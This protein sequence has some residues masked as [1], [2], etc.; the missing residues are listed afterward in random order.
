MISR[1]EADQHV[2]EVVRRKV[3]SLAETNLSPDSGL[4]SSADHFLMQR[5]ETGLADDSTEVIDRSCGLDHV[6]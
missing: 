5:T 3:R 4:A 2:G 6:R 1:P